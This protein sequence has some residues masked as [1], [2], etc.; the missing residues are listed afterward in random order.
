V[1]ATS[2]TFDDQ[3]FPNAASRRQL[4]VAVTLPIWTTGR[5]SWPSRRRAWR[6]TSPGRRGRTSSGARRRRS[7]RPWSLRH[8][9]RVHGPRRPRRGGRPG[10]VPRAAG[11]LTARARRPRWT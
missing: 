6:A 2:N 9:A 10:D 8:G 4:A 1:S 11:A 5:G 3:F 7:R